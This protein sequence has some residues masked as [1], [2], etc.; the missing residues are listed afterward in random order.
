MIDK[1][2]E[3]DLRDGKMDGR[4]TADAPIVCEQCGRSD[5]RRHNHCFYCGHVNP[6]KRAFYFDHDE[7]AHPLL[8]LSG[9]PAPPASEGKI[10]VALGCVLATAGLTLLIL[11]FKVDLFNNTFSP[12]MI[13]AYVLFAGLPSILYLRSVRGSDA[14][15]G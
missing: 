5:S 15:R 9:P 13:L 12:F 6:V 2:N 8:A 7:P 4:E 11:R 3:I 10:A 14:D 1:V